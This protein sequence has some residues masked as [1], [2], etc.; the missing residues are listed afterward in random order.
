MSI[1]TTQDPKKLAKLAADAKAAHTAAVKSGDEQA[2]D[3]LI[4]AYVTYNDR[5]ERLTEAAARA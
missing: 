4:V 5:L 2:A 1:D 3:R